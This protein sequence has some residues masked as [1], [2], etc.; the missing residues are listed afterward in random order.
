M[1]DL[2]RVRITSPAMSTA[3]WK[4]G[5]YVLR[6][7]V[8]SCPSCKAVELRAYAHHFSEERSAL[9]VWCSHCNQWSVASNMKIAIAFVDR[10]HDASKEEFEYM[11]QTNWLDRLER[12]WAEGYRP[13]SISSG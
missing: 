3:F 1:S 4:A 6:G 12:D 8:A 2:K 9:W 7:E 5:M 13:F 10:Y 11:E